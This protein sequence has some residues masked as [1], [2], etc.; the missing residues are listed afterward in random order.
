MLY[1]LYA[2]FILKIDSND[3]V[4]IE[5]WDVVDKAHNNSNKKDTGIKL[6][7]TNSSPSLSSPPLNVEKSDDHHDKEKQQDPSSPSLALDASTVDVYRNTHAA[8]L[9]FDITKQWTFDYINNALV[10]IPD[11][12]AVLVLVIYNK[13]K[14][15]LL[16]NAILMLYFI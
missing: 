13:N 7:H 2:L 9:I 5:V 1:Y 3:I 8:L 10:N 14:L 15:N 16:I 11:N 12:V 6:E 4:K